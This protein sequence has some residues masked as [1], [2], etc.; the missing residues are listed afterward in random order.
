MVI[1]SLIL[2]GIWVLRTV[3]CHVDLCQSICEL[4]KFMQ[5]RMVVHARRLRPGM[6]KQKGEREPRDEASVSA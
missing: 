4:K 6:R 2:I 5:S 3:V 1:C